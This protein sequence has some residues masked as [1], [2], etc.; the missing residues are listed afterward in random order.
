MSS[1]S[2]QPTVP[3]GSVQYLA[4]STVHYLCSQPICIHWVQM[5]CVHGSNP[6]CTRVVPGY[7]PCAHPTLCAQPP[8]LYWGTGFT[9]GMDP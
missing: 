1:I 7:N 6:V 3:T 2:Q 4:I 5:G 8:I 9:E